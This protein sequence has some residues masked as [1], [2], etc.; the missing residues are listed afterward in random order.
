MVNDNLHTYKNSRG[1][2]LVELL[3]A[4]AVLMLV[5]GGLMVVFQAITSIVGS[6][7]FQAGAVSLATSRLEYIRSL[8]YDDVGTVS[9]IPNGSIPQVRTTALN[10]I[11]YTERV[12]IE[13]IDAPEDGTGGSDMNGIVADYK[14]VKVEYSWL[15]KGDLKTISLISNIIP[16]GIETTAGGGTLTVNVF[17]ADV[18]PVSGASVRVYNDT[19]TSTIDTTRYTNVDG[20]AMFSGAPA[21][22]GYEI[23]VTDTGFSTDQ[24][25]SAS[26][27]NPN[28]ITPHVAVLES[29]VSTMNFQIDELSDLT[30]QTVGLPT[31]GEFEDLFDDGNSVAAT[32]SVQISSGMVTLA[33]GPGSYSSSG[34]LFSTAISPSTLDSWDVLS[35]EAQVPSNTSMLVRVY[36]RTGTSTPILIPDSDLPGNSTGFVPGFVSLASLDTSVYQELALSAVLSSTD[37]ATTSALSSWKVT[38]TETQTA[39]ANVPF[40]IRGAK[41]IGTDASAQPVYKYQ[42]S[43]T[44]DGTGDVAINDIEW[45][46]YTV[47]VTDSSYDI[48]EAC[49]NIPYVLDPGV[50]DTLTL[51]LANATAYSFRVSVVD[52]S[53]MVIPNADVTLSRSGF[54]DTIATSACG[55]SFFNSGLSSHVDYVLD[56]EASGYADQTITDLTIDGADSLVVILAGS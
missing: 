18:L 23:T 10:G 44:T 20:V 15:D 14:L 31:L 21:L 35:Y 45:D 22:S 48:A 52:S 51:T 11:T 53:G 49:S 34:T 46:V 6:S 36:D 25:Y 1:M 19:G 17:D 26:S 24:T 30:V 9:G 42:K 12:L 39:I 16:R 47:T 40:E 54:N 4:I 33:G 27:S 43:F 56:V 3:I 50:S 55:Q 5:F 28:P 29:E 32:S 7:K 37:S 41:K 2:T 38:Y 8:P 13:Y